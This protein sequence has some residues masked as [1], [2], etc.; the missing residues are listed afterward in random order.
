MMPFKLADAARM[1]FDRDVILRDVDANQ[2]RM[3]R[4]FGGAVRLRAKRS[5]RPASRGSRRAI[6][7][8]RL[9]LAAAKGADRRR[10]RRELRALQRKQSAKPG[11]PP[12]TI[13]KLLRDNIY[14]AFDQD[15]QS[16]II[17]PVRLNQLKSKDVPEA[18]EH[19]GQS[20]NVR[21]HKVRIPE[22]PYMNPAF[23]RE[24]RGNSKALWANSVST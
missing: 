16:V 22:H 2:F 24:I 19:G 6:K 20:T 21:G 9:E 13:T 18:L 8:K 11:E 23:H 17:G 7:A 1:F 10:L 3:M 4:R 14:F 12:R 15:N 5:M